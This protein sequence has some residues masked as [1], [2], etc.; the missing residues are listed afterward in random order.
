M[1]DTPVMEI[2]LK[3]RSIRKYKSEQIDDGLLETIIEAGRYAPSGGN[4]QTCHFIV[5]Q[6]KELLVKLTALVQE[7]LA[8]M[9]IEPTM[10]D[11]LIRV[12]NL[13]KKGGYDFIYGAPTLVVVANR[14]GYTNAMA[15]SAVAIENMLLASTSLGIGSCWINHLKWLTDD[16]KLLEV[17]HGFGLEQTEMICGAVS[18]GYPDQSFTGPLK[19]TGNAITMEK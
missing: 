10:Y 9:E 3:R 18:L 14:R 6:N 17:M 2:I 8:A 16:E 15:D 13:C 7:R 12:I 4:N 5:I 1:I 11:G 19:R